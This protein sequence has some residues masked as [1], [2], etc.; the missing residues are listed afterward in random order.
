MLLYLRRLKALRFVNHEF[1]NYL[2]YAKSR[3][4]SR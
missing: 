4:H 3:R 1:R 2:A